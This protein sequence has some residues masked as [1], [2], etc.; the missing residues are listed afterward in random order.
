[1][2]SRTPNQ[3]K[4]LAWFCQE[5]DYKP[6]LSTHPTYYFTTKTGKTVEHSI[7]SIV[8]QWQKMRDAQTAELKQGR[9]K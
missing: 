8:L 4:A 2:S 7:T 1:M 9:K 6:Q 3:E 5:K